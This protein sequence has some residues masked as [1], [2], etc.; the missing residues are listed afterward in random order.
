MKTDESDGSY[1]RYV[2]T[3]KPFDF[4]TALASTVKEKPMYVSDNIQQHIYH[5]KQVNILGTV[6]S[7]YV[8]QDYPDEEAAMVFGKVMTDLYDLYV[9]A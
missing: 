3:V 5:L 6:R 2:A 1:I 4:T 9:E 7:F 8:H